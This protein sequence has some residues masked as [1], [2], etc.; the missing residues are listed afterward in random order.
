MAR[1]PLRIFLCCQQA[2]Q[3]HAV[4]AYAFWTEYFRRG[5]EEAGHT[6]L[7]A[8]ACDWA[9]GLLPLAPVAR[10]AWCARTWQVAVDAIR[11]EHARQPIDLFLAYLFP[12]QVLPAAIHEIRELGVPCVNFFCDNVREFRTVPAEYRHFDLHWV[13]EH[14]A[15][16]LY[17][18]AGLPW[19]EAPM[20]C[21]VPPGQRV[22]VERE[23]LPVTF[24]GTRDEQRER[25][26]AEV[27]ALGL[28]VDLRG[29]GWESS[30]TAHPSPASHARS[31]TGLLA[32]QWNYFRQHGAAAVARK[33]HRTLRPPAALAFD[34]TPFARPALFGDAYWPGLRECT[35]CLGVNRYPSLRFPADRPDSYSRLR[36]IEAPMAGACYLTEWTEGIE[37]LY[38]PGR[39][40]ET[41]RDAGELVAKARALA[42]DA[43]RRRQLRAAGQQRALR[44]HSISRTLERIAARLGLGT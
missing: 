38:E 42:A 10:E 17:R 35:V 20:A 41:Y 33:W 24:L 9:E 28:A 7:E 6:W 44:D 25:L 30:T 37:Q 15:V 31:A 34:F 5:V 2:L 18:R 21:W 23:T 32:N 1:R 39:E 4:P 27:L 16:A 22:P 12:A 26:F 29:P 11:R 14:K 3:R 13:P 40:I 8:P 43:P 19:I 36:D